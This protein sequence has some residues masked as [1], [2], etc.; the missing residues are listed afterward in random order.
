[1]AKS[2]HLE[3]TDQI[4]ERKMNMKRHKPN[5][6]KMEEA[7]A[8]FFHPS[9]KVMNKTLV[10]YITNPFHQAQVQASVAMNL[11]GKCSG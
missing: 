11:P 8:F 4:Q 6:V 5:E 10:C 2:E 3:L 7:M 1:M 9:E